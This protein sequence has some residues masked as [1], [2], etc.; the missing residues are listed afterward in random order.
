LGRFF[1]EIDEEE[2]QE[3]A[4]IKPNRKEMIN[5]LCNKIIKT[6]DLAMFD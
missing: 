4:Q 1:K 2:T 6:T 3:I 5:E